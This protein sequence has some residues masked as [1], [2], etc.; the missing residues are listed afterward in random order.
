MKK[1]IILLSILCLSIPVYSIKL[2][3]LKYKEFKIGSSKNEVIK[4]LKEF[5]SDTLV[6]SEPGN[7]DIKL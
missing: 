5:Y 6:Y 2:N 7:L 1:L 4:V 3:E